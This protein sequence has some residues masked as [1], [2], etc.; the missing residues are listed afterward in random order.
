MN[1]NLLNADEIAQKLNVPVSWIYD[2]TRKGGPE[3]LPH[4][5]VG[6]YVRFREDEVMA[7]IQGKSNPEQN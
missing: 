6:K 4:Y 3:R 2:R 1:E 5:K 7:Y